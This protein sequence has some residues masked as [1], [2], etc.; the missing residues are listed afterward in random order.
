V[1][2]GHDRV[3]ALGVAPPRPQVGIAVDLDG[4]A[5][6]RGSVGEPAAGCPIGIRPRQ[7]R[8]AGARVAADRRELPEQPLEGGGDL[9]F[10]RRQVV[11]P[12]TVSGGASPVERLLSDPMSP[13][14][15]VEMGAGAA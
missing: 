9:P 1:A 5:E 12:A 4:Q 6:V 11:T 10:D 3:A 14:A 7:P 15:V 8:P 13:S 2:A